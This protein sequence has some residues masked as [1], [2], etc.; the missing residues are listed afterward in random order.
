[1]TSLTLNNFILINFRAH[2]VAWWRARVGSSFSNSG[3]TTYLINRVTP[4]SAF[5][6]TTRDNDI[7]VIRTTLRI[8]YQAGTIEP[9]RIVGSA[10]TFANNQAVFAIG[11]GAISAADSTPSA[12]LR[13]SQMWIV[14]AQTCAERY[15]EVNF[16]VTDNMVCIGWLDVGVRGQ[17]Q[18]DGGSPIVDNGAV[19][20]V[21]SWAEGCGQPRYPGINTRVA[22][23]SQWIVSTALAA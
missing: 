17:C 16:L 11:W 23:Y 15:R 7:A 20:G 19:V 12:Q 2:Q 21:F 6:T 8:I 4:H 3:G 22:P 18:G 1:L 14:N 5:S 9:A 10:H 13:Q